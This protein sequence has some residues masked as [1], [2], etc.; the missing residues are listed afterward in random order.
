MSTI[1]TFVEHNWGEPERAPIL[2]NRMPISV[3]LYVCTCAWFER[4]TTLSY[5]RLAEMKTACFRT[6]SVALQGKKKV[7]NCR[8][9]GE[10][11]AGGA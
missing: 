8:G 4:P 5:F 6:A 3:R 1:G 9:E 7:G 11:V 2:V 10:K